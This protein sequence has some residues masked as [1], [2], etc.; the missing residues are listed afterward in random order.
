MDKGM[1][2]F[3]AGG[4]G[5]ISDIDC[6]SEIGDTTV[7]FPWVMNNYERCRNDRFSLWMIFAKTVCKLRYSD[8]IINGGRPSR[9]CLF[10]LLKYMLS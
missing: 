3:Y 4:R 6:L 2:Y 9:M 1:T 7:Y 10:L 5:Y 8:T